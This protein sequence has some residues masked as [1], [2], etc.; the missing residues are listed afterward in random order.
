M[1][2]K[3]PVYIISKGRWKRRLTS[4]AL[5]ALGVPYFIVVEDQ[6]YEAYT[7]VIDAHKVLVLPTSYKRAYD[8]CDELGEE[9]S[10]GSGA[11]RNFVW[12]HS[13]ASGAKRHWLLDDNI[14]SF[15]RLN[16]NLMVKVTSGTIF[17]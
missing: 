1:N 7:S 12:D 10:K 9:F 5:E 6:E 17:R 3:Y 15:N 14:A 11:A 2:P 13:T 16:R 4:K 8:P